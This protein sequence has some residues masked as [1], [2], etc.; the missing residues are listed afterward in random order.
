MLFRS[1]VRNGQQVDPAAVVI[2]FPT[3]TSAWIGRGPFPRR[4]RTARAGLDGTYTITALVPGEYYIAAVAEE[5]FSDWQDP[6]LLQ[7]LTRIARQVRV[8]DGERR[9]QDLTTAVVR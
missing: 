6:A 8:T 3:D 9:T 2:A 4:V 5:G 1:Q 7:G